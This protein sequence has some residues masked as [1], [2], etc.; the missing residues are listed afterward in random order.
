MRKGRKPG[1]HIFTVRNG[2]LNV[3]TLFISHDPK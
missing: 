2:T 1:S 3:P